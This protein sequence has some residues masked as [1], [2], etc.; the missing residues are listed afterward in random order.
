MDHCRQGSLDPFT[1]KSSAPSHRAKKN[2]SLLQEL[3]KLINACAS[4]FAC[5]RSFHRARRH[6]LAHLASF[7]RHTISGLLRTQNRHQ[8]DWS[9]DYRFFSQ[10]RFNEQ[11]VFE[12]VRCGVEQT[13]TPDQPLVVAMDDSLLRKTGRKICGVRWQRDP[14]GPPFH[15]NFVRGLRVLQISA[16]LPQGQGAARMVPIDFQ[17]AVLPAKPSRKATA[18]EWEI[19]HKLRVQ[20][21]INC[22]GHQRVEV[23]RQEMDRRGST[24]RT[25]V[26]GVDGRFTNRTFLRKVPQRTVIVGR[27]RK[28]AV[29]HELPQRQPGVGRR[30]KYGKLTWT[31]EGLLGDKSVAFQ[32]VRAFATGRE[33]EFQIKRMGPVLLRLDRAARPVQIMVIKPLGY[34]LKKGG[35]LLYRQPAFLICTDPE[36]S[37]ED[38]LQDFL[39]RWDIEVNFRDEKTILGIG[40][41]QVRTESSNQNAPA[42]GVGAY[43]LLL[44]ASV[45][46]YG[47]TGSPDRLQQARWHRRKKQERATTT[48]L[49]NQ[50][51]REL[52]QEAINPAHLSDFMS[53]ETPDE[54]SENCPVPLA[55]AVFL[56][57]A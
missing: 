19:Y 22:L 1:Q 4:A 28:D 15:V 5:P 54:K 48:E 17:H 57:S 35:K 25:L 49:I 6:L 43:S 24:Q 52:W 33:H 46:A 56:S 32:K 2:S 42:L 29:V 34:R 51:R 12:H 10:D 40:Q 50:L 23:L 30:R 38:F 53:R 20:R 21:N 45:N 27:L 36:M 44:L 47:K 31:P 13:L 14:L 16:A 18:Q 7:G 3:E 39:W 26:V 55:S 41:A 9:A 37:L 11:A 8:Q